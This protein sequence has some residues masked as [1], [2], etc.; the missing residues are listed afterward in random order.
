MPPAVWWG[1]QDY[2]VDLNSPYKAFAQVVD[3]IK[4]FRMRKKEEVY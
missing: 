1:K 2:F 3:S 4:N